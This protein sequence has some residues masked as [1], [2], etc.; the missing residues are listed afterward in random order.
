MEA[1]RE[2]Q[3][4]ELF[5]GGRTPSYILRLKGEHFLTLFE[6]NGCIFAR[7]GNGPLRRVDRKDYWMQEGFSLVNQGGHWILQSD[8]ELDLNVL[9]AMV[10]EED[11]LDAQGLIFK[12]DIA[13]KESLNAHAGVL[14]TGLGLSAFAVGTAWLYRWFLT[15]EAQ[16]TLT[17]LT[18]LAR[19]WQY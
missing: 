16:T 14:V 10:T 3:E 7:E 9:P 13:C 12:G 1:A 15:V 11:K 6:H 19:P 18:G 17:Y 2:T 4:M 5:G 8:S